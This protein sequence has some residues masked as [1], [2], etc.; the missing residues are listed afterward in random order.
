MD[1]PDEEPELKLADWEKMATLQNAE[2]FFEDTRSMIGEL[3]K[4]AGLTQDPFFSPV[5]A[6]WELK[7]KK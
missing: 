7:P 6:E 2:R 1:F 4:A 5:V 3:H